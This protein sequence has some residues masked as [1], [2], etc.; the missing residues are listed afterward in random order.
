MVRLCDIVGKNVLYNLYIFMYVL[1]IVVIVSKI[2]GNFE[3]FFYRFYG[4]CYLY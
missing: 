2:Y 1:I 4:W 3:I